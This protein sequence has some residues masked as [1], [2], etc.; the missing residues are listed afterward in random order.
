MIERLYR[1]IYPRSDD[2]W[3]QFIKRFADSV[4]HITSQNLEASLAS[5]DRES[6]LREEMETLRSKVDE[7]TEEVSECVDHDWAQLTA[8]G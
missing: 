1:C 4:R 7:L 2:G 8:T 6:V 5:E 3:R